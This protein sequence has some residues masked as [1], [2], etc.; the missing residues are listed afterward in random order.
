MLEEILRPTLQC[1]PCPWFQRHGRQRAF[2]AILWLDRTLRSE[3]GLPYW[4]AKAFK[5]ACHSVYV[6][7]TSELWFSVW[8][9]GHWKICGHG[10]F[11]WSSRSSPAKQHPNCSLRDISMARATSPAS[12]YLVFSLI[13]NAHRRFAARIHL[14]ARMS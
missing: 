7:R 10:W 14:C 6:R 3:R 11:I 5:P 4:V 13:N 8:Q 12:T 9:G 2:H 1:F